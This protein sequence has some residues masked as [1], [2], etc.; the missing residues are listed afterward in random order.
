[1]SKLAAT[2][3]SSRR[4]ISGAVY[5][6]LLGLTLP[7]PSTVLAGTADP[8]LRRSEHLDVRRLG[9]VSDDERSVLRVEW[10]AAATG[11]DEARTV[12]D[13][14]E[15]LRRMQGTIGEIGRLIRDVPA[16][17]TA[18]EATA[19]EPPES[20]L[21]DKTLALAGSAAVGLLAIWLTRRREFAPNAAAAA[22]PV[23]DVE[24]MPAEAVPA[25]P[26]A[27]PLATDA[28]PD[29][30][31]V[32]FSL[33]EADPEAIARANA[34]LQKLQDKRSARASGSPQESNVE[35]ALQLAEIMLSLGL[36]E[37]AAQT[38]VEYTETHPRQAVHHWLKLLD[39]YRNSGHQEDFRET[40]EKLRQNFNIQA[41]DWVKA[42]EEDVP[43]LENYSRLSEHV[44][45]TWMQPEACIAYLRNLLEDNREG[46]RAGFPRPVA[47]EILLLAD[48]LKETSGVSQTAGVQRSTT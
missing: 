21:S 23:A 12:E 9:T 11:A 10:R 31:P 16:A 43:T 29:T 45:Q 46:A 22:A 24:A 28:P 34:R 30:P 17:K 6:A 32:E 40:A 20:G 2:I 25:E 36:E 19:V 37:G 26:A 8:E 47:E 13:M 44:Q 27:P 39:I 35:P 38:L 41:A 7:T 15:S 14:L 3:V 5:A 42:N 18:V 48:I 33:E 4:I 1:M